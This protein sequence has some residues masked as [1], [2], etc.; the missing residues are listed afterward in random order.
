M[1][2]LCYV[3]NHATQNCV[4]LSFLCNHM[5]TIVDIDDTLVVN[6][7]NIPTVKN[8]LLRMNHLC[9][10][11]GL[12]GHYSH[13]FPNLPKYWSLLTTFHTHS[14]ES[15]ITVLEEIHPLAIEIGALIL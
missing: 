4:N 2:A 1:C 5:C 10:V 7:P 3:L 11:C 9:A 13:H 14:L 8:K 12:Y 15:E 6:V